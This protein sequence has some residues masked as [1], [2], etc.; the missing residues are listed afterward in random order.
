MNRWL[1]FSIF[2]LFA[3]CIGII[4]FKRQR[5]PDVL[6]FVLAGLLVGVDIVWNRNAL[7]LRFLSGLAAFGLFYVVYMVRG[8]LGFGDVKYAGVIGYYLGF[9]RMVQGLLYAVLLGLVFWYI[10]HLLFRWGK[11]Q[12]FP[13]GP[14][15]GAGAVAAEFVYWGLS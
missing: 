2:A 14:W 4:D 6:L 9:E 10:G 12:R 8:G 11:E 13:F 5:I 1:R 15:L 7:P 3:L